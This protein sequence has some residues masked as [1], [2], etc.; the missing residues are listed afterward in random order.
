ME[1]VVKIGV[2]LLV[3]VLLLATSYLN[4]LVTSAGVRTFVVIGTTDSLYSE[5]FNSY[6]T[7]TLK[8]Y[9]WDETGSDSTQARVVLQ[10]LGVRF[11]T[12]EQWDNEDSTIVS[13]DSAGGKWHMTDEAISCTRAYRLL[14]FGLTGNSKIGGSNV[15]FDLWGSD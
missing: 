2:V 11:G 3:A 7:M 6:P 8:W 15:L 10:S 1:K 12:T 5:V 9:A 4:R 14:V 13:A